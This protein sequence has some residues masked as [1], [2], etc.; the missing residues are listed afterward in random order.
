MRTSAMLWVAALA[1]G[2]AAASAQTNAQLR[3][4][5]D[6]ENAK[7]AGK[8]AAALDFGKQA[9]TLTESGGDGPELIEL[10]R[11]VGD[12]AAQAGSD[13]LARGYYLRA[14]QLQE[15]ALGPNHPDLVS[16]LSALAELD[17]KDRRYA[18][19]EPHLTRIVSIEQAASAIRRKS[20]SRSAV[21]V[22]NRVTSST[23][24][25]CAAEMESTAS[26][27][28]VRSIRQGRIVR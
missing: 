27:E 10:L 11:N 9:V 20:K 28:S 6:F 15:A 4:Y 24:F 1:L 12:F 17:L 7:S 19:A 8:T 23:C 22:S 14:L 13:E 16:I 3:A 5:Q 18:D 26:M 25:I 21:T 2:A